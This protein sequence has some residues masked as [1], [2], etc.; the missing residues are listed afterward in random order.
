MVKVEQ[1]D[2]LRPK[3]E[4]RFAKQQLEKILVKNVRA[5]N[6]VFR[7]KY[8]YSENG[9]GLARYSDGRSAQITFQ[10]LSC[11]TDPTVEMQVIANQGH[12]EVRVLNPEYKE[13]A[14]RVAEQYEIALGRGRQVKVIL[15]FPKT[16]ERTVV[17]GYLGQSQRHNL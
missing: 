4:R 6:G 8:T 11:S 2:P 15:A 1:A 9:A 5:R 16:E 12:Y 13:Q 10:V 7:L 17:A 3:V 14:L